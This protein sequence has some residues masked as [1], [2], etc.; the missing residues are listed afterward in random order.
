MGSHHEAQAQEPYNSEVGHP[1]EEH[2]ETQE[3]RNQT[4]LGWDNVP[5]E[6]Y[7]E[8]EEPRNHAL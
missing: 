7:P 5:M 6:R 8:T 2:F 1:R 4:A 3:F